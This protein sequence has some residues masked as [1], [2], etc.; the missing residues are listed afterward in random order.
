MANATQVTLVS[1]I[2]T[3]PS[4]TVST[5]DAL[6]AGIAPVV[7]TALEGSHVILA[8]AG[9]LYDWHVAATVDGWVLVFDA[10]SA[11][12]DGAVTP[13]IARQ[14][15]AGTTLSFEPGGG[16]PTH[17]ATGIAM[18]FSTTGPFTKT[19]SATA[20]FSAKARVLS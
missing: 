5:I 11:P 12:A 13:K 7:S 3:A 18:V 2:P 19:G 6:L 14:I 10:T 1:G 20:F 9:E 8:S 17:F 16:P 4:G 15:G